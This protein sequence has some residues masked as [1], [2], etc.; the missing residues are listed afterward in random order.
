MTKKGTDILDS[1]LKHKFFGVIVFLIVMWLIFQATFG[2]G[3]YPMKMLEQ[4]ILYIEG[5]LLSVL[6][7]SMLRSLLID[8]IIKGVGGVI[9]F[10]PNIIILFTLLSFIEETNYMSR[11]VYLMDRIM[12]PFG[13]NGR[14]F[15]S[16]FM[17][18]GCNVPAIIAANKIKN[19][20][21]R[22]ISVF[23]NPLIPCSSRFTVYVLFISAFFPK[24]PGLVLFILY[25]FSVILA[26]TTSFIM[27]KTV[28][29]NT[30]EPHDF[31]FPEY[32]LPSFKII[33]RNMWFNAQ[34]FLKKISGAILVA[35]VIIWIL[36][37][38]PSNYSMNN[39][40]KSYISKVGKM[41]EP[42]IAPLGFDWKMG[43]S[44]L[45]GIAAKETITGTL[46]VLYQPEIHSTKEKNNFINNLHTQT[47]KDGSRAGKKVFTPLIAFSFIVFVSLYTPCIAT[48]V[49]I[50]KTTNNN[51]LTALVVIYT[52]VL[53]WIFSFA[54]YQIGSIIL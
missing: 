42:V 1:L 36:S 24:N 31:I 51:M 8:G 2:I 32:T 28:F 45:S 12:Q 20:N 49:T 37:Y 38:F 17:G 44:L 52:L 50:K 23:I 30:H 18:L 25:S 22:L 13:L 27:K 53:A 6:P 47:Y 7:E 4:I 41:I 16:L 5:A 46:S 15:I 40:E 33:F 19:K 9:V 48:L 39:I 54:I 14:S 35:S 34:L 26:L 10:L 3:Y 11:V 21:T 29:K 43:V